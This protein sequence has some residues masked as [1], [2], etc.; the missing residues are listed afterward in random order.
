[1]KSNIL[2]I[3]LAMFAM[4]SCQREDFAINVDKTLN[5]FVGLRSSFQETDINVTIVAN[6]LAFTDSTATI[7]V[8][9][10]I[11]DSNGVRRNVDTVSVGDELLP[12][13][14]NRVG[15][16]RKTYGFDTVSLDKGKELFGDSIDIY[17]SEGTDVPSFR[18][19]LKIPTIINFITYDHD[20]AISPSKNLTITWNADPSN[21]NDV[22][23]GMI[24]YDQLDEN[25]VLVTDFW[26]TTDD[27]SHTITAQNLQQFAQKDYIR[28][29]IHR[30]AQSVEVLS[31][32]QNYSGGGTGISIDASRDIPIR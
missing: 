21:A 18:T 29:A 31:S 6:G 16:Y 25:E 28:I 30:G 13:V 8:V 32:Y 24:G 11:V 27:G 23:I 19:K 1:M 15:V 20:G 17:V 26:Q 10:T 22:Y 14:P 12:P 7:D 2:L 3:F 9:A 4:N 5:P